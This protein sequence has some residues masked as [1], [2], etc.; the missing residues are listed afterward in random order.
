MGTE[1][2]SRWRAARPWLIATGLVAV[3]LV[4]SLL[5]QTWTP[6]VILVNERPSGEVQYHFGGDPPLWSNAMTVVGGLL[7][8]VGITWLFGLFVRWRMRRNPGGWW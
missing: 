5:A 3:G 4:L 6:S 2:T 8:V 1:T 7:S